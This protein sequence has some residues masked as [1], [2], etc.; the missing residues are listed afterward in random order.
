M[1]LNG[2]DVTSEG[3]TSDQVGHFYAASGD[4]FVYDSTIH[5]NMGDFGGGD[6]GGFGGGSSFTLIPVLPLE[7]ILIAMGFVMIFS[8][9]NGFR[10]WSELIQYDSPNVL[11]AGGLLFTSLILLH[12]LLQ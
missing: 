10:K 2:L 12:F 6:F 9:K 3:M 5:G 11:K 4:L 7:T 1:L 8:A